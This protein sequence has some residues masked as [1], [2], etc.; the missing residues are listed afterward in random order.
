MVIHL[1]KMIIEINFLKYLELKKRLIK[2]LN[3]F[4][5]NFLNEIEGL[6]LYL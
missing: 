4:S 2:L 1:I 5:R 3:I 6:P